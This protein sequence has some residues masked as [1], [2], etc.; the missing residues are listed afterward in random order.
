MAYRGSNETYDFRKIKT[1][2]VF[3]NGVR[4]NIIDMSMTNDEQDQL[5]RYI[6]KLKSKT[7]P[8]NLESK[9]LKED[10]LN[11]AKALLKR[12]EM[13]YKAFENGIFLKLE[14]LKK[15]KGF[16]VLTPKQKLQR[17]PIVLAQIKEGNNSDS[18]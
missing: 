13:V 9:K 7:K 10:V 12:R 6:N 8:H 3:G 17:L 14:E 5:L 16:K 11:S 18:L 2:R 15:G 1:I 4:N